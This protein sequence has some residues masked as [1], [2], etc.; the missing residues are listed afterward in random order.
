MNP[1][2]Y[3]KLTCTGRGRHSE[4]LLARVTCTVASGPGEAHALRGQALADYNAGTGPYAGQP[5]HVDVTTNPVPPKPGKS[6][7]WNA[8]APEDR[9]E[10]SWR[11]DGQ[12][13]WVV[14]CNRCGRAPRISEATMRR[15]GEIHGG[16][17]DISNLPSG[18]VD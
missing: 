8:I 13:V 3:V 14:R 6:H 10:V 1:T 4:V 17:L 5:L 12:R 9:L 18:L 7:K 11:D 15:L 2:P 16:V